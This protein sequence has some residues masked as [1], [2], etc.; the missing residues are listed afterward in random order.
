MKRVLKAILIL[1]CALALAFSGAVTAFAQEGAG[2]EN[3]AAQESAAPA[4]NTQADSGAD[5]NTAAQ[6]DE[7]DPAAGGSFSLFL[8]TSPEQFLPLQ[9]PNDVAIGDE[10]IA[11]ADSRTSGTQTHGVI[12]VFDKEK[13]TYAEYLSTENVRFS[14]LC[15]YGDTLLFVPSGSETYIHYLD[16]TTAESGSYATA[17]RLTDAE[18]SPITC[19]SF[20]ANGNSL[21]Y[22]TLVGG[23][24]NIY[25]G[26]LSTADSTLTAQTDGISLFSQNE[27]SAS[28]YFSVYNG[29][30]Y[31]SAENTIHTV[32]TAASRV[33]TTT[34]SV[35]AFAI[36]KD[37]CY[38]SS[39]DGSHYVY[40]TETGATDPQLTAFSNVIAVEEYDNQLYF[41][42]AGSEASVKQ[43]S[44]A[45]EAYTGWEIA[46]YSS[47]ARRLGSGAT[48][49]SMQGNKLIFADP[50]NARVLLYDKAAQTYSAIAVTDLGSSFFVCAGKKNFLVSNGSSIRMFSY[51]GEA[52]AAVPQDNKFDGNITDIAYSYGAYYLLTNSNATYRVTEEGI[53]NSGHL[54]NAYTSITADIEG[55]ILALSSNNT[56]DLFTEEN[57]LAEDAAALEEVNDFD[58]AVTDILLDY[59]GGIYGLTESSVLFT[60]GSA[61]SETPLALSSYVSFTD[62]SAPSETPLD[63][64][65]YVSFADGAK[66]VSFAF[67][68]ETGDA[69]I[70]TDAGFIVKWSG[71]IESLDNIAESGT[72][73]ALAQNTL[74]SSLPQ[75]LLVTIEAGAVLVPLD[76]ARLAEG[77]PLPANGYERTSE[78][79]IAVNVHAVQGGAVVALYRY[80]S[81][82]PQSVREYS[83]CF[84]PNGQSMQP[85]KQDGYYTE[86]ETGVRRCYTTNAVCL[87][88]L[89]LMRQFAG[90]RTQ[91]PRGAAVTV[92]G[93]LSCPAADG[94]WGLDTDYC[95][96]SYTFEQGTE[97]GFVPASYCSETAVSGG[98]GTEQISY[99]RV[100]KG[101]RIEL[102][103]L[104]NAQDTVVL[105]QEEQVTVHGEADGNGLV[106]VTYTA[107]EVT[108]GG[109][110]L[111]ELLADASNFGTWVLVAVAIVTAAVLAST[112]YLFLRKQP[113]VAP[114]VPA[115]E[116]ADGAD[117][118]DGGEDGDD[119]SGTDGE[120]APP[121]EQ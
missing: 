29:Q 4:A 52:I 90:A 62:G 41:A 86:N 56:V 23:T 117:E 89:P 44:T 74:T 61:P 34:Y 17:T 91:L 68:F 100:K 60:D 6:A 16:C 94:G 98:A 115:E 38:Y 8:P 114:P 75:D 107:E 30:V 25:S 19:N 31:F 92:L 70:L 21:Y 40:K 108:Y 83:L 109:W 69:Y 87:Y 104:N 57:F 1:L 42:V 11:V 50:A 66:A 47:G 26:T 24:V 58:T 76:T 36:V 2:A 54:K 63:L 27:V 35:Y 80:A 101:E 15:F 103:A 113:M 53:T 55:N 93:T 5:T 48:S 49:L 116:A 18:N 118:N 3:A 112:C 102:C 121:D 111:E 37:V 99:R 110:V 39:T 10:Y 12:Y 82:K 71:G 51:G 14:S 73:A 84:L 45:D 79:R 96:V 22:A 13:G 105:D 59:A 33:F 81:G 78:A 20:V 64:S 65:S 106:Y 120:P 77:E 72:V 46:Q 97:Y 85:L 9:S 28:P 88:T 32:S 43:V 95:F 119:G 7:S 67:G